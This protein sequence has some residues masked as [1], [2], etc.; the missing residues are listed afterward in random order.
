MLNSFTNIKLKQLALFSAM[1]TT[2]IIS[3]SCG[4]SIEKQEVHL[5]EI[6]Q[7]EIE[8][9]IYNEVSEDYEFIPPS[10]LQV[11]SIF[12]KAGLSYDLKLTNPRNRVDKYST[13]L[14][15]ALAFGIYSSDLA[16]SVVHE[17]YDEA[18]EFLKTLRTL[19]SKIGLESI[20]NTSDLI[21]RFETNVAKQDSIID[22]LILL[23]ENTDDYI[24]ENG[25]EDLSVIYY[26]GAWIE[27][28]YM[29]ANTVMLDQEK[30]VG[31]LISEQMTLAEILIKGLQHIKDQSDEIAD[32]VDAIQAL[33]DT[34]YKLESVTTLGEEADYIDIV[35]TKDEITLMSG[36]IVE[37][38]ES[39]VQ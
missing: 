33:V 17:K 35:L 2:L 14:S 8:E 11:A 37:L 4:E 31:V 30:R 7:D 22:I 28:M 27:G 19:G 23:Q 20:F 34:Y 1:L 29:G 3:N 26:T 13:K 6:S 36:K 39:I 5:P 32:L 38:R 21:E 16:Y 9:A 10:A 15:Q 24:E 25:K 18:S 12:K